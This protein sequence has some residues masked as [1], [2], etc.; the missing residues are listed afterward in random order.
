MNGREVG[1]R[2]W[3]STCN[4]ECMCLGN[5]GGPGRERERKDVVESIVSTDVWS[6][7]G[8]LKR[9]GRQA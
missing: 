2:V 9:C 6:V 4:D 5:G 7:V 3:Q 1:R 8:K